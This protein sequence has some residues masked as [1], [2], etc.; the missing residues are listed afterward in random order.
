MS[1]E[2]IGPTL[3]GPN[4]QSLRAPKTDAQGRV[5]KHNA[6]IEEVY[7]IVADETAKVHEYYLNQIPQ[8][9]G[10]MIQD[11][12]R[13][14]GLVK[15]VAGEGGA[16]MLAPHFDPRPTMSEEEIA[17]FGKLME[18]VQAGPVATPETPAVS[19]TPSGDTTA[20]DTKASAAFIDAISEPEPAA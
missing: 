12:L 9:V 16:P 5:L 15:V 8:F 11:A 18:Q 14:Y 10:K 20:P 19:E 13:D 1:G 2:H 4:G 3:L 17:A 7:E 6:K